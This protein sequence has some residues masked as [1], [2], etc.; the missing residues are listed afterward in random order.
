MQ[1]AWLAFARSGNPT[2]ELLGEWPM[3]DAG[4]RATMVFGP[5]TGVQNA[6]RDEELAVWE[7]QR[8]LFTGVPG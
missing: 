3:W 6:P 7:Q 2:H 1:P 5:R 8:P 4:R